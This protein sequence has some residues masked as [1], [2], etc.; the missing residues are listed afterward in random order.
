MS[1]RAS[2]DTSKAVIHRVR[3]RNHQLHVTYTD[4]RKVEVP[5]AVN[6]PYRSPVSYGYDRGAY[7]TR[8]VR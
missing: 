1:P 3:R 8:P 6:G 7:T 4:G 2:I 5:A